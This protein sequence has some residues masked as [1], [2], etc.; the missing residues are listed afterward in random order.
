MKNLLDDKYWNKK[1]EKGSLYDGL[2][3]SN[4]PKKFSKFFIPFLYTDQIKKIKKYLRNEKILKIV[5]IG[6]APGFFLIEIAKIFSA[7]PFGIEKSENG[8]EMNKRIFTFY[9]YNEENV[10]FKDFFDKD[11][12]TFSNYFDAVISRGFIEHFDNPSDVLKRHLLILRND[13]FIIV[14]VPNKKNLNR[15]LSKFFKSESLEGHNLKVMNLKFFKKFAEENNLS[16]IFLGY[17]G[18]FDIYQINPSLKKKKIYNLFMKFQ[19]I[20]YLLFNFLPESVNL[21]SSFY[22]PSILFI[23]KKNG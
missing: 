1:Y 23:A 22:S 15:F 7:Q 4:L 3:H 18:I 9:G 13:G 8:Y 2:Y 6:S 16:I 17:I 21:N 10:L 12:E 5:E 20:L 19:K 14:T 11:I